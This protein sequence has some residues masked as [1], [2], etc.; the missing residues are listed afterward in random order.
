MA[1]IGDTI[2]HIRNG[3]SARRKSWGTCRYLIMMKVPTRSKS[4]PPEIDETELTEVII[5]INST[6]SPIRYDPS[7]SDI[8]ADDWE[9]I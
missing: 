6:G 8:L 3:G 4:I 2:K 5:E 7:D 9:L 1:E